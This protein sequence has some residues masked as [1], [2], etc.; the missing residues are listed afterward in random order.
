MLEEDELDAARLESLR[1]I[2]I[3]S[4]APANSIDPIWR[5]TAY[6]LTPNDPV[7]VEAFC[8]IRDAMRSEKVAAISRLVLQRRERA[9]ALEAIGDGIVLWTLRYGEEV[10]DPKA[11]FEGAARDRKRDPELVRLVAKLIDELRKPWSED[12]VEDPSSRACWSSSL[13][14]ARARDPSHAK[15]RSRRPDAEQRRQHHG[16]VAQERRVGP[17]SRRPAAEVLT[18]SAPSSGAPSA[19]RSAPP[20]AQVPPW[21]PG[22]AT[23]AA[24]AR[25]RR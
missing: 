11:Y 25:W 24:P 18:L 23:P 8:V 19:V 10:H 4:F 14:S 6:Y 13:S 2:D 3:E 9:V 17:R 12:M 16:R 22:R 7:G 20:R 21:I 5:Q 1:T 15:R